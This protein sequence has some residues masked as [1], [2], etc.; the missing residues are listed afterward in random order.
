LQGA[1]RPGPAGQLLLAE[2]ESFVVFDLGAT[3]G[4]RRLALGDDLAELLVA[5]VPDGVR[6]RTSLYHPGPRS[7]SSV[8]HISLLGKIRGSLL[9]NS[10]ENIHVRQGDAF[11]DDGKRCRIRRPS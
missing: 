9:Q 8:D 4:D 5:V 11:G 10:H 1:L 6:H 2:H 3:V 7:W